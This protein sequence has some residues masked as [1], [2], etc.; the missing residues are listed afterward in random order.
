MPVKI[1]RKN[2]FCFFLQPTVVF[3][4][5]RRNKTKTPTTIAGVL[6]ILITLYSWASLLPA[7]LA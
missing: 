5:E 6:D 2:N 3:V 1:F 4:H 7:W